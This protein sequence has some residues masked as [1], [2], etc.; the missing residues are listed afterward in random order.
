MN[1]ASSYLGLGSGVLRLKLQHFV[2]RNDGCSYFTH[3]QVTLGFSQVT[4]Q[5]INTHHADHLCITFPARNIKQRCHVTA[6]TYNPGIH[7][8]Q[9][10]SNRR[11]GNRTN[12]CTKDLIK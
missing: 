1:N 7:F 6:T 12:G 2:V 4:L 11:S 5:T 8:T 10:F 9:E 3:G